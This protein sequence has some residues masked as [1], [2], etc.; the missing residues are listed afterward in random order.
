M[1][2]TGM[3]EEHAVE[4]GNFQVQRSQHTKSHSPPL[5]G[6]R[7]WHPGTA[8]RNKRMK[9]E[10]CTEFWWDGGTGCVITRSSQHAHRRLITIGREECE[11]FDYTSQQRPL[12][13]LL[14]G[15]RHLRSSDLVSGWWTKQ[16][17]GESSCALG[18]ALQEWQIKWVS[19]LLQTP[20]F[21]RRC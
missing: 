1:A 16:S 2:L 19:K 14:V 8:A 5:H 10:R 20:N 11:A 17:L 9:N 4:S 15:W 3:Y 13:V 18:G 7:L 6:E 12:G 21:K